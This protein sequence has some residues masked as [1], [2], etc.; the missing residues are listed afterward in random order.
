MKSNENH[1]FL[2]TNVLIG[3]YSGYA[4]DKKC[5]DYLFSLSGKRLYIST[6]SIAQIVSVFHKRK[7]SRQI[8]DIVL[9]IIAKFNL[10]GFH[11][12]D[13]TKSLNY[14]NEDMEDNIQYV[15]SQKFKCFWFITNNRK[16][17]VYFSNIEVLKPQDVRDIAQS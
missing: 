3:A 14:E 16:D 12:N 1:I 2:D 5:L 4:K 6:L 13:I 8:K 17:Y 15:I 7:T 11:E 9:K 10:I